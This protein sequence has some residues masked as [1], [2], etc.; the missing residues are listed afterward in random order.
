MPA[1]AVDPTLDLA[2]VILSLNSDEPSTQLRADPNFVR[3]ELSVIQ[4]TNP[5]C[6]M[7]PKTGSRHQ[8]VP[9][10]HPLHFPHFAELHRLV[11]PG[12]P[13]AI[14][15]SAFVMWPIRDLIQCLVAGERS[16]ATALDHAVD[17]VF[18][19]ATS[20]AGLLPIRI[21]LFVPRRLHLQITMRMLSRKIRSVF[22]LTAFSP[23]HTLHSS[24]RAFTG[25]HLKAQTL[26]ITRAS[27]YLLSAL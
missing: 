7:R 2:R 22:S 17:D 19:F 1:G 11:Y 20:A 8:A 3:K 27:Y 24:V 10:T 5:S 9:F 16:N 15:Q 21:I 12:M 18:R 26:A 6:Q 14:A 13:R 23:P 4:Y 25:H